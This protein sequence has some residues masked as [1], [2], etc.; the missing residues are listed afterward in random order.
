MKKIY[1]GWI[2]KSSLEPVLE[3]IQG[4]FVTLY[5]EVHEPETGEPVRMEIMQPT[6]DRF[7]DSRRNHNRNRRT[8]KKTSSYLDYLLDIKE[9][10]EKDHGLK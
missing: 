6:R 1:E 7:Q 9:E 4:K 5:A 3:T 10:W 2:N 8:R